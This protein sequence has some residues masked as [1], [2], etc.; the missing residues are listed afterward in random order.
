MVQ[1]DKKIKALFIDWNKTLS[2]SLFWSQL[3]EQN[4]PYHHYYQIIN[5]WLFEKNSQL[6]EPWM[7]GSLT[8]E[9]ICQKL[10]A[11]N[12]LEWTVVFETLK[13][14][15][16]QMSLCSLEIIDLIKKIRQRNI[17]VVVATDNMDTFRRFTINGLSLENIF[18]DFLISCEL[19]M[20]KYDTKN[21]RIPFFEPFLKNNKLSYNEVELLDDSI[22]KSG[23]YEKLGFKINLVEN[24]DDLIRYLHSYLD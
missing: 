14:S 4:H 19:K 7:R 23:I 24:S 21:Q 2:Q 13:E 10:A 22:D 16:A 20:L 1:T 12:D 6:L 3:A 11:E 8:A 18:D 9:W 5:S 17:K 15:C